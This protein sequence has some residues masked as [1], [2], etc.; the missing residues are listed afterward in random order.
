MFPFVVSSLPASALLG[1]KQRRLST[2]LW[3]TQKE[4]GHRVKYL[5]ELFS[6]HLLPRKPCFFILHV[7]FCAV[8]AACV[9]SVLGLN[10]VEGGF[11]LHFVPAL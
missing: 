4:K 8:C 5:K 10:F 9:G 3:F 2:V 1:T 6:L 7:T 11:D